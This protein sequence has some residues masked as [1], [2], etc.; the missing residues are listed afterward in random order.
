MGGDIDRNVFFVPLGERKKQL[1][2][3]P[4][5][6]SAAAMPALSQPLED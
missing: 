1:E 2:D 6:E 3:I 4:W 5:V